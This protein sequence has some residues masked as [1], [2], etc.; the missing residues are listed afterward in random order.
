[1]FN[2]YRLTIYEAVI[3]KILFFIAKILALVN[4]NENVYSHKLSELEKEIFDL[5]EIDDLGSDK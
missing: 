1:M 2:K 4:D 3:V 5:M